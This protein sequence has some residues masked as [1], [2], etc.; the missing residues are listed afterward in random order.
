MK[1]VLSLLLAFVFLQV[2]TWAH[3]GG[4]SYPSNAKSVQGIYA[5]VLVPTGLGSNALGLFTLTSPSSGLATGTFAVFASG[6][7]FKG[8][9]LGLID[10][11]KRTLNSV[12]EGEETVKFSTVDPITGLVTISL[13]T[14][15]LASGKI[16][17]TLEDNTQGNS[18]GTRLLGTGSLT[19]SDLT[20]GGG[21]GGGG[22]TTP[23]GSLDFTVD[24]F[25]QSGNTLGA[26]TGTTTGTTGTT[27]IF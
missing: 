26:T 25:K 1:K 27:G 20:R 17:A 2:Q 14:V 21:G 8:T 12:A 13:R 11:D 16:T 10:P 3:V 24:G 6:G 22:L 19:T 7:T 5:G 9:I 18:L 15:A 4:P 23:T